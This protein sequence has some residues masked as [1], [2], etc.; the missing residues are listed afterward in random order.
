MVISEK[1]NDLAKL[2]LAD[3]QERFAQIDEIAQSNTYKVLTAFQN[4]KVSE[5]GFAGTTGYGYNDKGRETLDMLFADIMGM[6]SALVRANFVSGTHA[7]TTALFASLRPGQTIISTTG[8]PYDTLLSAIGVKG[9]YRGSLREYGIDYKQID[10][11]EEG[12]PDL[13]A[14]TKAARNENV[15]A[16]LIQRSRGYSSRRALNINEIGDISDAVHNVRGDIIVFVDNC[17]GEFTEITEPGDVGADLIAGSLIK[18]PGGG[19]APTGGYV[20]GREDLV[21]AASFRLTSPGIGGESGATLGIN[22]LLFQGVFMAPHIVA[23][24]MKTAVFTAR[25]FELMGYK[26]SPTYSAPRSDII[27]MIELG[28]SELL[29]SFCQ[30]IQSSSPIDSFVK[31]E[32][33]DMPGY[34]SPVIM[35]AGTFI[36]GSSI[37]LSADGPM[38]EPYN[39]YI[40]GGLT[41][42]SAKLGIMNAASNILK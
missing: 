22:R 39:V 37:E 19:L 32:A 42:E 12:T 31:P 33:W 38:R 16:V 3:A 15:G 25:L 28:S 36:Q 35:A 2:A 30:G 23:Q 7:I 14:I 5:A 8:L 10:L 20:A 27:Q 29:E 1:V 26:T 6:E 18:N 21:E 34:D 4:H 11:L 41:F 13:D 40:Q 24:A 17:Y 9:A